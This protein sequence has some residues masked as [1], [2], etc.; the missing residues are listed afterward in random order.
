MKA[1]HPSGRIIIFDEK[2]HRYY[3]EDEPDKSLISVTSFVRGFF[4]KFD[5]KKVSVNYARKHNLNAT[6]LR[7]EW[8]EKGL[9]SSSFGKRCHELANRIINRKRGLNPIDKKE[10]VYFKGIKKALKDLYT[11]GYNVIGS[12]VIIAS[13]KFGIAGTVDLLVIGNS[14]TIDIIDWKTNIEIKKYNEFSTA[15]EPISHLDNCNFNLY[16]LQLNLY[17][18]ILREENYYPWADYDKL[19]F[20]VIGRDVDYIHVGDMRNEII[21]MIERGK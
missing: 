6:D 13:P 3:M 14:L 10:K 8:K 9:T 5:A 1:T 20:H 18:F 21:D 11:R 12:E 7:D 4:P 2:T 19:I 17:E 15:L 16:S